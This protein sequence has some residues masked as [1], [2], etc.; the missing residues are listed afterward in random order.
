MSSSVSTLYP[1]EFPWLCTSAG[2]RVQQTKRTKTVDYCPTRWPCVSTLPFICRVSIEFEQSETQEHLFH[3][4]Y[5]LCNW[6]ICT[7][8]EMCMKSFTNSI[9]LFNLFV[10]CYVLILLFS[11]NSL[12][13][14][15]VIHPLALT[16]L[17]IFFKRTEWNKFSTQYCVFLNILACSKAG[18]DQHNS[19]VLQTTT[20]QCCFY[21]HCEQ[22]TV[23]KHLCRFVAKSVA[24]S[25]CDFD[26][27][28]IFN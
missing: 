19:S 20:N 28:G 24:F 23:V 13:L 26:T 14:V 10:L 21:H 4:K 8:T 22:T 17:Y 18:Y 7:L 11:L 5:H 3:L 15:V 16:I 27:D 25:S 6:N 12:V 1:V 9:K 2:W